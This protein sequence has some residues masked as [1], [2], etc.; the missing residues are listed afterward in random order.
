MALRRR[1]RS[2]S[3]ACCKECMSSRK[4]H[5]DC[6]APMM[7]ELVPMTHPVMPVGNGFLGRLVI[8]QWHQLG[9]RYGE[10]S[11]GPTHPHQHV[12]LARP[13][14]RHSQH[15]DLVADVKR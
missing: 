4:S 11:P 14:G 15:L 6:V 12:R 10:L 13:F 8:D 7:L 2:R 1:S 3:E 5:A 9:Q